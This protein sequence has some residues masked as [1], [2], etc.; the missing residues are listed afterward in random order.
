MK[1]GHLGKRKQFKCRSG[2]GEEINCT[3]SSNQQIFTV[4]TTPRYGLLR[5]ELEKY[6][7]A[8]GSAS[9]NPQHLTMESRRQGKN[10]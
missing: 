9:H 1:A 7:Q 5:W 3:S 4:V 8:Q 6:N 2:G 10:L